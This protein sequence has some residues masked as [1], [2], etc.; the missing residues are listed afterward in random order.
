MLEKQIIQALK[1]IKITDEHKTWITSAL[2][3]SFKDEQR[4]TKERL[5]SLNSQKDRLRERIDKLYLNKL[6]GIISEVF[7]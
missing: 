3:D 4:Y 5:N 6:D 1:K 7:G 2:A